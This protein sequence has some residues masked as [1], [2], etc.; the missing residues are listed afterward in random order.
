MQRIWGG[1]CLLQQWQEQSV[2]WAS[3]NEEPIEKRKKKTQC[4]QDYVVGAH[5]K[6]NGLVTSN[7]L[8]RSMLRWIHVCHSAHTHTHTQKQKPLPP[9]VGPL[10]SVQYTGVCVCV[11]NVHNVSSPRGVSVQYSTVRPS[12]NNYHRPLYIRTGKA[13]KRPAILHCAYYT[14]MRSVRKTVSGGNFA[15]LL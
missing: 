4:I 8:G 7:R 5:W 14:D 1:I 15:D 11:Y 13:I 2:L 3:S 9:L 12:L 10:L 6:S